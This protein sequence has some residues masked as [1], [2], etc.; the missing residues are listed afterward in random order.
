MWFS[1]ICVDSSFVMQI[2]A[3]EIRF[4]ERN[5]VIWEAVV[6]MYRTVNLR[7]RYAQTLGTRYLK[8]IGLGIRYL[9]KKVRISSSRNLT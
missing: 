4:K 2:K 5:I 8:K 7:Y 6:S 3:V 9:K 1:Y